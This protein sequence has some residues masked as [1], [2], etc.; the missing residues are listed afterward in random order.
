MA[1][2]Y[3]ASCT[4]ALPGIK[5]SRRRKNVGNVGN[6]NGKVEKANVTVQNVME[7]N[8]TMQSCGSSKCVQMCGC[9]S[10]P[11]GPARISRKLPWNR[12]PAQYY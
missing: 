11:M 9:N 2:S 3:E 8:V 7:R 10:S 6:G 4:L 5:T 1:V 12:M